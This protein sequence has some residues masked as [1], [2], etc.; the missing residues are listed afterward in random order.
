MAS[1]TFKLNNGTSIP[2]VG[3]GKAS[4]WFPG[5]RYP[6]LLLLEQNQVGGG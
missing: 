5:A 4:L 2:A 1:Q 3:Y 6:F